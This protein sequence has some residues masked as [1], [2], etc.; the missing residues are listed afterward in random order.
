MTAPVLSV[1]DLAISFRSGDRI[2]P[3]VRG[4][5]FTLKP[6]EILG[7][8]GE[9][10][11]GKSTVAHAILR[12]LPRYATVDRGRIAFEGEDL[13]TA[14]PARLRGVR[15]GRI[16]MIFQ[17]P[18]SSL[19]PLHQAGRQ[20]A[21]AIMT[22]QGLA[23]DEAR[24]LALQWL[25]RVGLRDAAA[26]MTALP[27]QLSGGERQRVMIAM[28]L[29]NNP[30][31]LI[32]DEPTTA[33]DVTVQA[34]ILD[35]L[36][37]LRSELS[38]SILLI[39][40]D[41]NLVRGLADRV[42]VMQKGEIVESGTPDEVFGAPKHAYTQAL[43]RAHPE[44]L[45]PRAKTGAPAAIA[46]ENL[47][48][49]VPVAE[50]LLRLA[51][52]RKTLLTGVSLSVEPGRTLGVVGESGSGKTTLGLAL[53]R[54]LDS[55]GPVTLEGQTLNAL[56]GGALRAARR[57]MQ[58]VFQDPFAS[59]SPR[60]TIGGIV[61]EGLAAHEPSLS[62]AAREARA[63]EALEQVR[64]DASLV[65]R[66]PHELSGGQRQR[67]AIARA[68]ILK[69][70][71]VVLDEPTSALDAQTQSQ[72]LGLLK[73]LQQAHGLAYLFISHDLA[74]V[75]AMSDDILVLQAGRTVEHGPADAVLTHPQTDYTRALL[76]AA[77]SYTLQ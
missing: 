17:E 4:V 25:T 26:R 59:L 29:S 65:R 51:R 61:A 7:L 32:A 12:L 24:A 10:G 16:G 20:V 15:G 42:A 56:S 48:V 43:I 55:E 66:F 67:V 14:E 28:A 71:F 75:R 27:H 57:R 35:L 45:V 23:K 54:L 9:S 34:Q 63:A 18:M 77:T 30:A 76:R 33:L 41:L 8:A 38:L 53:L 40:H 49:S 47:S 36:R 74:A 70:K 3:A 5:S 69:P 60:M 19:N 22:H 72:V 68:M 58:I 50:G 11:S 73:D 39:S 52:G 6:G 21:E 64:L 1:D 44:P 46:C 13:A 2:N 37:R 62:P 31:V